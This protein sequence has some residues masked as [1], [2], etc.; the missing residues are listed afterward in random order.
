MGKKTTSE[1]VL[2]TPW[3]KKTSSE[4]SCKSHGQKKHQQKRP[5]NRMDNNIDILCFAASW[6][7][8]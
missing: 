4:P 1:T 2:Q 3:A 7:S 8:Q 6:I 5:A